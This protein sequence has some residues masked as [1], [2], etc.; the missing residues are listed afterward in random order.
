MTHA[1]IEA[2]R[3]NKFSQEITGSIIQLISSLN[4]L[5]Y[6]GNRKIENSVSA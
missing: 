3:W 6:D 2:T 5:T 1:V 4:N